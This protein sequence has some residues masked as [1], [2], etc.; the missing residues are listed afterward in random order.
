MKLGFQDK[1]SRLEWLLA[2]PDRKS[3]VKIAYESLL[4]WLSGGR[5]FPDY[6]G[7]LMFKRYCTT[8]DGYVGSRASAIRARFNPTYWF[9]LLD[10]KLMFHMFFRDK[11]VRT[12]A[13]L[14]YSLGGQFSA[15]NDHHCI[16]TIEDFHTLMEVIRSSSGTGS[17]FV[18]SVS[19]IGGAGCWLYRKDVDDSVRISIY[20][21][22][23]SNGC[24]FEET[25]QQAPQGA[26]FTC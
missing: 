25:L 18:K 24:V 3:L 23:L 7:A 20:D 26:A 5:S 16:S 4:I 10:N 12:A 15:G 2:D 21:L 17:V 6:Y 9:T 11:P 13:L 22:C 19:G 1:I 8:L 14:G